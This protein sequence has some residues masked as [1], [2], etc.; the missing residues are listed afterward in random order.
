[1]AK[2]QATEWK[3]D[4][5]AMFRTLQVYN[6][7]YNK[8]MAVMWTYQMGTVFLIQTLTTV[9]TLRVGFSMPFPG[10]C[11]FFIGAL[12]SMLFTTMV[13]TSSAASSIKSQEFADVF[14][15]SRDKYKKTVGTS[16]RPLYVEAR[17]FF[18][19][20]KTTAFS[21]TNEVVDKTISILV[22]T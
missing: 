2:S 15:K 22:T 17:P 8:R 18:V 5:L 4:R 7:I 19:M 6:Q 13:Y 20:T 9:I 3:T 12:A 16:M 10:N 1:M 14:K 11:M 21:Y